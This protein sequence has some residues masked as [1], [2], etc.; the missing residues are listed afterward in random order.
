LKQI[1]EVAKKSESMGS[2]K[3]DNA[4]W[5]CYIIRLGRCRLCNRYRLN[6]PY[7]AITVAASRRAVELLEFLAN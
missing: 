4:R 1:V 3:A 6:I 7:S 5:L 2:G